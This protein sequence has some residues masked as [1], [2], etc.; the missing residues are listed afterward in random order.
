MNN[1]DQ[2]YQEKLTKQLKVVIHVPMKHN[3]YEYTTAA[4]RLLD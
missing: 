1:P 2:I 4:F 3:E